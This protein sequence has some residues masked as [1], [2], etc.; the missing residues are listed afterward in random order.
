MTCSAAAAPSRIPGRP[1]Q[2]APKIPCRL[3]PRVIRG[4]TRDCR[5]NGVRGIDRHVGFATRFSTPLRA[6]VEVLGGQKLIMSRIVRFSTRPRRVTLTALPRRCERRTSRPV[7]SV[8]SSRPARRR[9]PDSGR[10][11]SAPRRSRPATRRR[12]WSRRRCRERRPAPVHL[13][14]S[15][16]PLAAAVAVSRDERTPSTRESPSLLLPRCIVWHGENLAHEVDRRGSGIC[17]FLYCPHVWP[18]NLTIQ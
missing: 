15:R 3:P 12:S 13:L 18:G 17:Q 10:S 4:H 7:A 16:L 1:G 2:I 11:P 8:T 9:C 14:V 6:V 5:K